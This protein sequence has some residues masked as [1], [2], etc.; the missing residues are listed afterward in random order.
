MP[1][2][3]GSEGLEAGADTAGRAG[4]LLN[5][6]SKAEAKRNIKSK[7]Q[8]SHIQEA[9]GTNNYYNPFLS[10]GEKQ[11]PVNTQCMYQHGELLI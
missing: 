10:L 8:T 2:T 7:D 9:R 1:R 4:C 11:I 6:F 3:R 5:V